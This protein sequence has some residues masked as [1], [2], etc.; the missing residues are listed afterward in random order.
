[1]KAFTYPGNI[2]IITGASGTGKSTLLRKLIAEEHDLRFSVSHTTRKPRPGERDGH[3][4]HFV[5][6]ATFKRMIEDQAFIEWAQVHDHFYGTAEANIVAALEKGIDILVDV[7]V[8][9]GLRIKETLP[10][11][12]AIFI[13]PPEFEAL[14]RRLLKRNKDSAEVIEKRLKNASK[15]VLAA[16]QYDFVVVNDDF[17][18]CLSQLKSLIQADRLRPFRSKTVIRRI[19]DTF[20]QVE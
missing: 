15:E 10:S 20:P 6:E 3:D 1:M 7:D 4:Y 18:I 13:L 2:Y 9:G 19:L 14:R 8:Q 16:S 5:D 17:E 11:A 12:C